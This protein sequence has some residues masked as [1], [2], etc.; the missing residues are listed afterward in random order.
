MTWTPPNADSSTPPPPIYLP[1]G[2]TQAGAEKVKVL[3]NVGGESGV[4]KSFLVRQL[5]Q[6]PD[7]GPDEVLVLMHEDARLTYGPPLPHIKRVTTLEDAYNVLCGLR[8]AAEK[9]MRLP[10]VGVWD[11]LT[12]ATDFFQDAKEKDPTFTQQGDRNKLAEYGEMGRW[13]QRAYLVMRNQIPMDWIVLFSTYEDPSRPLAEIACEGK[14]IPK[15][16]NRWSSATLYMKAEQGQDDPAEVAAHIAMNG[17][18][19]NR[20]YG[21][22]VKGE[23]DGSFI[24]RFFVTQYNGEIK[25]K[26]HDALN[27]TERAILPDVLR[28]I[29]SWGKQESK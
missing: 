23:Y 11:S 3:L 14:V 20:S 9:G 22:N 18:E 19:P 26:G 13:A 17:K 10:K 21:K 8:D 16:I 24:K 6:D 1:T 28:K 27:L 25:A 12:G 5:T 2:T 7:Y 4:G 29:H 15:N